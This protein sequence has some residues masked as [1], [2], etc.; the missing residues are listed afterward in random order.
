M[1]AIVLN[2]ASGV[3]RRPRLRED[4]EALFHGAG[5]DAARS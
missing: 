5:I 2:L 3:K 1:I 4:I